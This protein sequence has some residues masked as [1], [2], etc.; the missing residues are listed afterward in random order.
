MLPLPYTPS[1]REQGLL[2]ISRVPHNI[3]H[4]FVMLWRQLHCHLLR[5]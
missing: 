4:K 2:F 5:I 1:W 3:K